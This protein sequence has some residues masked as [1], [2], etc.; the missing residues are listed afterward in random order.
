MDNDRMPFVITVNQQKGGTGKTFL[1]RALAN[2]L[3]F[4]KN[5]RILT[6]DGDYNGYLSRVMYKVDDPEGTIGELFRKV[7][8]I[9]E[10][11]PYIKYH[12]IHKNIDL[13]AYDKNIGEKTRNLDTKEGK[14]QILLVWLIRNA[15]FLKANYD[16]IIIDTRNDLEGFT[17]NAIAISDV[18]LAPL[19]QMQDEFNIIGLLKYEYQKFKEELVEPL[20]GKSY[21]NAKIYLIGNIISTNEKEHREFLKRLETYDEYLTW[22]PRKALF[23]NTLTENK[24]MEQI[25]EESKKKKAHERFYKQYVEAM[26]KIVNAIDACR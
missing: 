17:K 15:E 26:E 20:S 9:K 5:K 13:I 2:Y 11:E 3:A 12:Q 10:E 22:L 1:S 8:N 7:R 25:I 14:H 19:D 18:I 24:P 4:N 6:I 16:Y 21:V 23:K